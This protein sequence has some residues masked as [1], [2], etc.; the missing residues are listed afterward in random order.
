[1]PPPGWSDS[2]PCVSSTSAVMVMRRMLR[3][4][5]SSKRMSHAMATIETEGN[6]QGLAAGDQRKRRAEVRQGALLSR[7]QLQ[8]TLAISSVWSKWSKRCKGRVV[9]TNPGNP[10]ACRQATEDGWS[11]SAPGQQL[12]AVHVQEVRC[13]DYLG[14]ASLRG[15]IGERG[16][17]QRLAVHRQ[18]AL[19]SQRS[20]KLYALTHLRSK[21][22]FPAQQVVY[23]AV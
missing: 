20:I 21:V 3:F 12:Q 11:S 22:P 2:W 8:S 5:R 10:C 15:K 9:C 6:Q 18:C 16:H 4:L 1:M 7:G 13:T 17:E 14:R 19:R 23:Q